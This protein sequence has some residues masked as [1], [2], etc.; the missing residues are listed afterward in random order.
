MNER[1]QE[2]VHRLIKIYG[3]EELLRFIGQ[4]M[5]ESEL[6]KCSFCGLPREKVEHLIAVGCGRPF[7]FI[8]SECINLCNKI[9]AQAQT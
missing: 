9:I 4:V 8:C 6:K 7:G 1:E 3:P 2:E 5:G